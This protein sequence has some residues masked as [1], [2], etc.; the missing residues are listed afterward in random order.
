LAA[1]ILIAL[2]IWLRLKLHSKRREGEEVS[3]YSETS[4]SHWLICPYCGAKN[5]VDSIFVNHDDAE[6][7]CSRCGKEFYARCETRCTY[8]GIPKEGQ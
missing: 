7:D 5:E 1:L 2:P 3:H 8:F 4:D 6:T